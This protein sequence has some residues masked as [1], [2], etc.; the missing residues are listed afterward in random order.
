MNLPRL[1]RLSSSRS[2]VRR[3]RWLLVACCLA[4]LPRGRAAEPDSLLP[5]AV[6]DFEAREEGIHELGAKV[7]ALLNA[8]L[9]SNPRLILVERA[10]LEKLTGEHELSLSGVVA[11]Q[12][13]AKVGYLTGAKIIVTGKVFK[14]DQELNL[15]A[16]IIGTETGRV[17]GELVHGPAG[18]PNLSK[19]ADELA[20]KIAKNVIEHGGTFVSNLE[21]PAQRVETMLAGLKPGARPSVTIKIPETHFG[22]PVRDP[23]AETELRRIFQNAGCSLLDEHSTTPADWE[24]TGEAFSALGGRRGN[25]ISCRARIELTVRRRADGKIL[26]SERQTS[27]AVD[28]AEAV[29]AKS[30]LQIAATELA[31]RLL[32]QLVGR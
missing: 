11:P 29:A 2:A 26:T 20:D 19:L 3:C 22:G 6:F 24:I 21:T 25:L 17:Y 1:F 4:G 8:R 15:V 30:A 14:I 23:A 7:S 31:L 5:L 10:E 13:A 28:L 27:V 32:P 12:T 9:S 18:G 16:K